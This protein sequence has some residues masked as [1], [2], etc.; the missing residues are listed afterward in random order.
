MAAA[1]QR[2]LTTRALII[3]SAAEVENDWRESVRKP[4]QAHD[5]LARTAYAALMRTAKLSKKSARCVNKWFFL[6]MKKERFRAYEVA[7]AMAA[8]NL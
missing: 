4:A 1:D 7:E 3:Y 6:E 8:A 2:K 5:L